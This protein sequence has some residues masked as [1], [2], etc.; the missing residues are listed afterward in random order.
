MWVD[1]VADKFLDR[2]AVEGLLLIRE[3]WWE[4]LG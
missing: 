4:L 2:W 1:A 3:M